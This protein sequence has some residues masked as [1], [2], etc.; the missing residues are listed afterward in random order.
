MHEKVLLDLR[1]DPRGSKEECER[2]C[3]FYKECQLQIS[4]ALAAR[5]QSYDLPIIYLANAG[6]FMV[7]F[8]IALSWF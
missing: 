4:E 5:H 1:E 7:V 8:H 3:K 6:L 2:V